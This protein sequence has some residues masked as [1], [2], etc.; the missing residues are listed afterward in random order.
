MNDHPGFPIALTYFPD[1]RAANP[2]QSQLY[3]RLPLMIVPRPGAVEGIS[4]LPGSGSVFH[5]HWEDAVQRQPGATAEGFLDQLHAFQGR[6]GRVIWTIH[7]LAAHDP[8]IEARL[9]DLREGLFHLAD[10]IHLHSLPAVAAARQRW[11]L[12]LHK[13]RVIAH[14]SYDGCYPQADRKG[15]RAALGLQDAGMVILLPGRIA[16]YKQPQ[17]LIEAFLAVA[18]PQDRMVVAGQID[19]GLALP[20]PNDSRIIL[21]TT[22]ADVTEV[23]VLHAAADLVVLPYQLSLTSGSALLAATLARGVLGPDCPGLRDAVEAG[24][25]GTLYPEGGLQAALATA[26][27][28]G[29]AVWEARGKAARNAMA[30]RD[31]AMLASGW[32]DLILGLARSKIGP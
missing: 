14:P 26:L 3:D 24:R 18:G 5:L 30:G 20:K 19:A 15:A 22:H 1:Y 28:E 10:V 25:S 6:G 11:T 23:S 31:P 7:N 12:P 32:T 16:A 17:A 8:A 21:H 13:V 9:A 29:P 27:A 4:A 2:V